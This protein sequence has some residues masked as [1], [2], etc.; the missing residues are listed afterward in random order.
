VNLLALL[1]GFGRHLD[2]RCVL[3]LA[4]LCVAVSPCSAGIVGVVPG[5]DSA[6][7]TFSSGGVPFSIIG[8]API[9]QYPASTISGFVVDPPTGFGL[10]DVSYSFS[11][12]AATVFIP[13]NGPV[14][15]ASQ[16]APA[17]LAG[18]MESKVDFSVA[19]AVDGAGTLP[20]VIEIEY[21]IAFGQSAPGMLNTFDAV[22]GYTST[23]LGFLGTSE[24]HFLFA[25]GPGGSPFLVVSGAD[26]L[27]PALPPLDTLTLAGSFKLVADGFT[28]GSTEIEVFGVPEP[29]SL[30]LAALGVVTLAICA[31]RRER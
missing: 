10:M 2:G 19:F 27:L 26:L 25:G 15:I 1:T 11:T 13:D 30:F 21:P 6:T 24:V 29:S 31:W 9:G 4:A 16:G 14:A 20:T 22:V 18:A 7:F 28:G 12:D 5:S 23:A 8:P 17:P 3:L